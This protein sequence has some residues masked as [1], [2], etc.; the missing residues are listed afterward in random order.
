MTAFNEEMR[1][2]ELAIR[3]I[4][5]AKNALSGIGAMMEHEFGEDEQLNLVCRSQ[6]AAIFNFF[7]SALEE[8]LR[9]VNAGK[10]ALE[11]EA[12]KEKKQ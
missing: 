10:D 5:D 11:R 1:K 3:L 8:P 2:L 6:A 4:E 12:W 7:G 9:V